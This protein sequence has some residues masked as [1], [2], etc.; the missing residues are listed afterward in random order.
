MKNT[1]VGGGTV[2]W[3]VESCLIRLFLKELKL[4]IIVRCL[5]STTERRIVVVGRMENRF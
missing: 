5:I 3:Q 2:S 1:I 4:E